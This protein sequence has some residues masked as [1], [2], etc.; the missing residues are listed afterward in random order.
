MNKLQ[1]LVR[2]IVISSIDL[3]GYDG[4]T[5]AQVYDAEYG[6]HGLPTPERCRDYLQGLPS[7]CTVPFMNA[8]ILAILEAE[9]ITKKTEKGRQGLI[10]LYWLEAG[11][12]LWHLIK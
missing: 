5:L 8:D 10:D 6:Y 9:G 3:S 2:Q 4:Q 1:K 11:N 7:V 12:Q